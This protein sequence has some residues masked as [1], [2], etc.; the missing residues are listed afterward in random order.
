MADATSPAQLYR[1]R[2]GDCEFDESRFELTV[3]GVRAEVQRKPLEVLA[4]LLRNVGEV[5]TRDELLERI[6]D[7]RPTVEHVINNALVKLRN[8]L[9]EADGA[10]I[11]TKPRVGYL[12]TGTVERVA[13]GRRQ[14]SA[15]DFQAGAPVPRREN[16]TLETVLGQSQGNEVWLAVHP[17]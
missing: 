8:A 5:V 16:F 11:V 17:R 15:F 6:W 13:V 14:A 7:G 9:G 4:F 10:R 12:F 2:F 1:F 3:R